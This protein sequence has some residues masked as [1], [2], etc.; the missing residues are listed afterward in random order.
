MPTPAWLQNLFSIQFSTSIIL[1]PGITHNYIT[2]YILYTY[3][4][5]SETEKSKIVNCTVYNY[6]R[7][8]VVKL[9]HPNLSPAQIKKINLV[10]LSIAA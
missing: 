3:H 4:I 8:N 1:Q 10:L 7:K 6:S 2:C 5:Y 9:C